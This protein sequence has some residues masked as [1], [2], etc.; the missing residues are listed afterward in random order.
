M[1]HSGLAL[2]K[3]LTPGQLHLQPNFWSSE[4]EERGSFQ[5]TLLS[6][7]QGLRDAGRHP[8]A[9]FL[10][11]SCGPGMNLPIPGLWGEGCVCLLPCSGLF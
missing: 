11:L 4:L 3:G 9:T 10:F 8:T 7:D 1:S 6:I 2:Q 5:H